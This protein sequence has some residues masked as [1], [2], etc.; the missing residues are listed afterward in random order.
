MDTTTA[1]FHRVV[2]VLSDIKDVG[3][4]L[5]GASVD[6]ARVVPADGRMRLDVSLTRAML[7]RTAT[8]RQGF[9]RKVKTPWTKCQLQLSHVQSVAVKRLADVAPDEHPLLN[10]EAIAGGYRLTV[11]TPDGLQLIVALERLEGT[12]GDVGAPIESP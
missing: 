7:E 2:A 1:G 10:A 11:L 12:F 4:L 6:E 8:V 5:R 9:V 3:E